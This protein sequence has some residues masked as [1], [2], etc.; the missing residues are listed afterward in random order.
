MLCSLKSVTVKNFVSQFYSCRLSFHVY[1]VLNLSNCFVNHGGSSESYGVPEKIPSKA[2][3]INR[4]PKGG[5]N[6]EMNN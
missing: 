4:P 6:K 5:T 2:I 1:I 3:N